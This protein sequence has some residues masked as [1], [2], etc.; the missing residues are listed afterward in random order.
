MVTDDIQLPTQLPSERDGERHIVS[1]LCALP[2]CA[3]DVFERSGLA[4]W[5]FVDEAHA[6]IFRVLG[7]Q[8]RHGAID[9][10]LA[11]VELNKYHAF[12]PDKKAAGFLLELRLGDQAAAT[13]VHVQ[14]A[15][16]KIQKS[17]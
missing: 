5:H 10:S 17:F 6:A 16:N 7:E 14:R 1:V 3:A 13:G 2:D 9:L 4:H 15:A 11:G 12:Q 8:Y